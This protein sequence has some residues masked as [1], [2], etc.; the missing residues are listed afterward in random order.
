MKFR[1]LII[2]MLAVSMAVTQL[3]AS[4]YAAKSNDSAKA[5]EKKVEKVIRSTKRAEREYVKGEAVVLFSD[6][7]TKMER[8]HL[9][10][11][12]ESDLVIS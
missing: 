2:A 8:F 9:Q 12:L 5:F 3:P 4:V 6:A 1:K 11:L 7:Y 10:V